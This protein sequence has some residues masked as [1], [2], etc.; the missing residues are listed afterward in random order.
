MNCLLHTNFKRLWKN[1]CFWLCMGIMFVYIFLYMWRCCYYVLEDMLIEELKFDFYYFQF[2]LAIGLFSAVFST[3]FLSREYSDGA[4][5]NKI[6]AGHKRKNIYLSQ[7]AVTYFASLLMLL[8]GIVTALIGLPTFGIWK[9]GVGKCLLWLL[10]TAMFT[11]NFCALYVLIN[12]LIP[13]RGLSAVL[14][15]LSFFI[16]FLA[17]IKIFDSLHAPAVVFQEISFGAEGVNFRDP[18]PNP[19]YI[20][21]IKREILDFIMDLLPA[22]QAYRVAYLDVVHPV[23][24]ILCSLGLATLVTAFGIFQF[25]RRDLK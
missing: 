2:A 3:I 24:M 12:I 9:I 20:E 22:G 23:R 6:I 11:L 8:V 21:G 14:T 25:E 7:L 5:R 13:N 15:V 16:L 10:I 4:V 1:K 18:M 19:R 17:A